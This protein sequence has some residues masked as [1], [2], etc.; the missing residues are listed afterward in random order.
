MCKIFLSGS[1]GVS[2]LPKQLEMRL[3][4]LMKKDFSFIVGDAPG[5]D[6]AFQNFFASSKYPHVTIYTIESRPRN[7]I[8]NWPVTVCYSP[9]QGNKSR[10]LAKD[11]AM[12]RDADAV[13]VLWDGKSKGTYNNIQHLTSLKKT[14]LIYNIQRIEGILH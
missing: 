1:S 6:T 9:R 8:A 7:N 14:V 5:A 4:S 3:A 12:S 10:Q 13:I 11:L 2:F